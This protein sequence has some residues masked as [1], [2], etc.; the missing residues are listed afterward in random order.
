VQYRS[1]IDGLRAIAVLPVLLFHAEFHSFKGGFVGVDVFF[2][3]SGYLITA[4]IHNEIKNSTFTLAHFYERRVRRILPALFF[5]ILLCLPFAWFWMLPNEFKAFLNSLIAVNTFSSNVFF[6]QESDYFDTAIGLKPLLHTWSLAI[7]EQFYL[8]FPFFLLLF[9]KLKEKRLLALLLIVTILSLGLAE[10]GAN[11]YISA[12]FYLLPS[13]AW[14]LSIGAMLAVS[15]SSRRETSQSFAEWTSFLGMGMILY[16]IF[17]FNKDVPFPSFWALIPVLGTALI[18]AYTNPTTL[19]GKILSWKPIWG[20]GIISYST[21][22]WHQPLFVF[23]RLKEGNVSAEGYLCLIFFSLILAYLT[24]RFIEAPFRNRENF[25]RNKIFFGAFTTSAAIIIFAVFGNF[26]SEHFSKTNEDKAKLISYL[27]YDIVE[28]YRIGSCFLKQNQTFSEYKEECF[29]PDNTTIIWGDSHAAALSF[30]LRS[31]LQNLTQITAAACPPLMGF[32]PGGHPN[33]RDINN[34]AVE[35]I[36]ALQPGLIILHANWI[37]FNLEGGLTGYLSNT[38]S[39]IKKQSPKSKILLI[40]GVPQWRPSLPAKMI[41]NKIE[42]QDE[43]FL[44]SGSYLNIQKKDEILNH[45]A[46]K[47][48]ISFISVLDSFCIYGKCL[49]STKYDNG[50]EPFAWD[51]GHLTRSSSVRVSKEILKELS[52]INYHH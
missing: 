6:W 23:A 18:I 28:P 9:R 46:E 47:N 1:E 22:L 19:I 15:Q 43:A 52:S 4:I 10:Y 5:V 32:D 21:Y 36:G 30:G 16:S 44:N 40:G 13:R 25:S 35:K 29:S 50:Y 17:F 24:W 3:I 27:Q 33:C 48:N 37:A 39:Y 12:N 41:K 42:L 14:E 8:L 26:Y 31:N 38:I 51:Y 11:H 7:E 34:F 20:I 2:V 45:I 49:T